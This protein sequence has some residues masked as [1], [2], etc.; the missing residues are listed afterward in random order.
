MPNMVEC[1]Y[2]WNESP[3]NFS[4][5]AKLWLITI[6]FAA[7]VL[8]HSEKTFIVLVHSDRENIFV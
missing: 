7:I 8:V 2:V 4:L 1:H 3:T 6:L 5:K